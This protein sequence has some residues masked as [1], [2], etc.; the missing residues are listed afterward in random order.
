M[1]SFPF[2]YLLSSPDLTTG[3]REREKEIFPWT[4]GR[5]GGSPPIGPRTVGWMGRGCGIREMLG[6]PVHV[7]DDT[8]LDEVLHQVWLVPRLESFSLI[9]L[10]HLL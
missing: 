1:G 2:W 4:G 9:T 10:I 8:S 6:G 3:W 7:E 5:R